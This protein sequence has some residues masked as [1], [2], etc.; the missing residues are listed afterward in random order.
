MLHI[1][2]KLTG[3]LAPL[4]ICN[5]L[6]NVF[7]NWNCKCFCNVLIHLN[8]MPEDN[9]KIAICWKHLKMF[10]QLKVSVDGKPLFLCIEQRTIYNL[11]CTTYNAQFTMHIAQCNFNVIAIY[12]HFMHDVN[13]VWQDCSTSRVKLW[14]P[15][16]HCP[17]YFKLLV[18]GGHC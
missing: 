12:T 9:W 18:F 14:V 4:H 17:N 5:L 2:R 11:Q 7:I 1:C 10:I 16:G 15:I 3:Q 13:T 6:Q 8:F